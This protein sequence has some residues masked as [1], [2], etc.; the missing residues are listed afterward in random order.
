[1]DQPT[2]PP[3]PTQTTGINLHQQKLFALIAGGLAFVGMILPWQVAS[4]GG[5]G[6]SS[7]SNGFGGWGLLSL[8]GIVGVIFATLMEDKTKPYSPNMRL[9]GM[10][11]F[12]GVL[13]GSFI[14]FMQMTGNRSPLGGIKT[15]IG[16]WICIIAGVVGLLLVAGIIKPPP[17]SMSSTSSSVPPSTPSS[18]PPPPPR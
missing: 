12:G 7:S 15:G 13:L 1:M 16:I 5:F 4:Y 8:F 11:S 3:Q 10:C 14:I 18:P 2:P 6:G 17:K 9:V